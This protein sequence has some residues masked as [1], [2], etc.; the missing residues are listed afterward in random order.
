M[1]RLT[2]AINGEDYDRNGCTFQVHEGN[3]YFFDDKNVVI[4]VVAA[5]MWAEIRVVD[6]PD[7]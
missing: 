2:S 1:L 6:D 7:A 3:V 4:A 5:G